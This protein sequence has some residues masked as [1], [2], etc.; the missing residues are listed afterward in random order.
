MGNNNAEVAATSG[1]AILDDVASFIRKYLV[2]DDHQLTILTLWCASPHCYLCFP[3]VPYLDVRSPE[4][5]SGKSLCLELLSALCKP[6]VF[7]RGLPPASLIQSFLPGR[8]FEE[9]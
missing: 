8:S 4:P 2:C 9:L 3:V 7:A 6:F 5:C 1:A